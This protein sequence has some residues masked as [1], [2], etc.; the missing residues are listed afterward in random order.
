MPGVYF[1]QRAA[2]PSGQLNGDF[3]PMGPSDAH[4]ARKEEGLFS[5]RKTRAAED[6]RSEFERRPQDFH[7]M[8]L[9]KVLPEALLIL[10]DIRAELGHLPEEVLHAAGGLE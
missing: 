7:S 4:F 10:G 1:L 5:F 2:L 3:L 9:P 8:L 6:A